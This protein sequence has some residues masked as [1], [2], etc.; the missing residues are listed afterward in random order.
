MK[1]PQIELQRKK[2]QPFP[3][4]SM[5]IPSVKDVDLSKRIV[6]GFYNTAYYFDSDKDVSLPG[7]NVKSINERGPN[8]KA[9]QKIKHL[10]NHDWNLLP[11]KIM[12]LE[13]RTVDGVIGTYFETKMVNTTEGND[14]LINYQEGVYDNHSFG[15]QY[16]DGEYVDQSMQDWQKY[17]QLLINPE[18]AEAVGYMFV[19]KEYKMFE[20]STVAFGANA[21]TPYL[22]VKSGNKEAIAIKVNEKIELLEKQLREGKQSDE[23]MVSLS[24]QTLQ[25]KQYINELFSL[26]P[27]EKDTLSKGR[28][29]K[30]TPEPDLLTSLFSFQQ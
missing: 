16:I 22:G 4:K 1:D 28:L 25:L 14:T 13:E 17:L 3:V 27:S 15:F 21:L 6:C 9:V 7:C 10:K 24:M 30:D 26:E 19:W 23:M 18:D 29:D 11:G 5:L 20:G 2:Q 8:S 12:L